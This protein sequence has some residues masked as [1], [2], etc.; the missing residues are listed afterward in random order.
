MEK[1]RTYTAIDFARYHAGNMEA[2][3]MH[4]LEKAALE[5][6]F[7]ADALEGYMLTPSA[8]EDVEHLKS[9]LADKTAQKKVR[10]ITSVSQNVWWR[11]AAIFVLIGIAGY[12]FFDLGLQEDNTIAKNEI[13]NVKESVREAPASD[14]PATAMM[15]ENKKSEEGPE[16]IP[17]VGKDQA[18]GSMAQLQHKNTHT[19]KQLS[20]PIAES[21]SLKKKIED[22]TQSILAFSEAENK[23]LAFAENPVSRMKPAD[24]EKL[25][26][27]SMLKADTPMMAFQRSET[28]ARSI[29][30]KEAE[31]AD[32]AV[33]TEARKRQVTAK[34][35]PPILS[36]R[37]SGVTITPQSKLQPIEGIEN[38]RHYISRNQEVVRDENK[39]VLHGT[40]HLEFSINKDGIPINIKVL[41]S[42]CLPCEK[43]AITLL[44]KGPLWKGKL[45]ETGEVT[46]LF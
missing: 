18:A 19:Q 35:N 40:V 21:F 43:Q 9:L 11:V 26:A 38:F 2:K 16:A 24:S 20:A 13:T 39:Q 3:E 44:E 4:A 31:L 45:G 23:D 1:K 32:V 17:Q 29:N 30:K 10:S 7:L 25:A 41:K 36:G 37:V 6:P 15:M 33:A 12:F 22:T 5:D 34:T 14:S 42:D 46:I 28:M 8:V 27:A